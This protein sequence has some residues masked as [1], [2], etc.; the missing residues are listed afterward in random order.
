[1]PACL[2]R[3]VLLLC[4]LLLVA[5]SGAGAAQAQCRGTDLL[6]TM[7]AP[8][9]QALLERASAVPYPEGNLWRATRGAADLVLAGTF[10]LDDPRHDEVMARLLPLLDRAQVLLVE[11]GPA[12]ESALRDRMA[13]DPGTMMGADG[14]ALFRELPPL[15]QARLADAL[16]QRGIPRS[17]AER[18][19]PWFLSMML[20]IPPCAL[21]V[22]ARNAGLDKR[23][24]AAAEARGLPVRA[25]EP[26]DTALKLF[27]D[28]S[29]ANQ[30]AMIRNALMF[31]DRAADLLHT[32]S[33]AFFS[34]RTRLIWELNRHLSDRLPGAD[35]AANAADFDRMEEVL[36]SRRNRA[37]LP[38]LIEAAESAPAF[39]AF[40]AL[41]LSGKEG[42][43]AL[44][45]A[46]GFTLERLPE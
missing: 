8:E 5:A 46:E 1:M 13:A 42:V 37:W 21:P 14:S 10:H 39:A 19:R 41:H 17:L 29:E 26:F 12:E 15:E 32:T 7:P 27:D 20:A 43:L 22:A 38:L 30:I 9:R 31:E 3:P 40:G 33:E 23:L 2:R 6:E 44:L 11:A 18:L 34:A 16:L 24:M 36:M 35:P 45:E 4:A 28:L 25:L